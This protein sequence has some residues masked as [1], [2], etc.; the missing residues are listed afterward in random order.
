M[1]K[2]KK[3]DSSICDRQYHLVGHGPMWRTNF[4]FFSSAICFVCTAPNIQIHLGLRPW[5]MDQ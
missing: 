4:P 3:A 5:A 1:K 2:E